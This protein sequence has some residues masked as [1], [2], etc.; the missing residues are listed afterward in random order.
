[1]TKAKLSFMKLIVQDLE[2]MKRFYETAFGFAEVDGF[3]TPDFSEKMF[4]QGDDPFLF[5]LLCYRDGR[6]H[7]DAAAHGP[8]GFVTDDVQ[9]TLDAALAAGATLKMAP[10]DVGP[11]R[12]AFVADPEGHEVEIIQFL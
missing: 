1:M 10:I 3:E 7:P 8:T 5:L 12:V 11:T 2:R 4:R 9:G 6:S